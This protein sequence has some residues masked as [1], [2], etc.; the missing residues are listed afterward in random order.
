MVNIFDDLKELNIPIYAE[1]DAPEELPDEY[2][3]ISEDSTSDNVSANN[4]PQ[5][6]LYEFTI[7]YYTVNAETLYTGLI[8]ALKLLKS[9]HYITSGVGYSN[10]TYQDKWFSRQADIKKIDYLEEN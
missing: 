7:K 3:T 6:V 5:S 1:G 4:E 9:K 8:N 2:F 10:S